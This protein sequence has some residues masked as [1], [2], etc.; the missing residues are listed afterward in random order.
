[1]AVTISLLMDQET[2]LFVLV[3]ESFADMQVQVRDLWEEYYAGAD[4]IVFMVDSADA[5]R[6]KESKEELKELLKHEALDNTPILILGNKEDLQVR[7]LL[8]VGWPCRQGPVDV[9]E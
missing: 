4:A 2:V 8:C 9:F 3:F 1:M 6:F 7:T 5:E